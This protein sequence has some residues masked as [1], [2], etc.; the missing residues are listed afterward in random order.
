MP[1]FSQQ[2]FWACLLV[3]FGALGC[4]L[5]CAVLL[6]RDAVPARGQ[7]GWAWLPLSLHAG[8]LSLAAFL[9]LAQVIVAYDLTPADRQLPWSLDRKSVVWGKSVSVRVNLGGRRILK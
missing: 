3:I 5:R 7:R 8:W 6:S 1:L 2:L 4:L 9:N